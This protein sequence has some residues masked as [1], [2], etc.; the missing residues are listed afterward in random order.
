MTTKFH[1]VEEKYIK[2]SYYIYIY[3]YIYIL[4]IP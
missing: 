3:I 2:H 1:A 4:I